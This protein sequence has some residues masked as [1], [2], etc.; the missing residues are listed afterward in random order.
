M[1]KLSAEFL[2]SVGDYMLVET[3]LAKADLCLV[4]GCEQ[5]DVLTTR[6]A[7]LYHKGYFP[8]IVVSGGVLTSKGMLE[9]HQMH[10]RLVALGVPEDAI[11]VEDKATNTG[12]NVNFSMDLLKT[13]GE[14]DKVKS[15]LAVGQVHA[16]RRFLMTLE[17]QWPDPVKMLTAPDTFPVP[18]KDWYTDRKFRHAV[19]RELRKI[20]KYKVRGFIREINLTSMAKK[21]ADLP[22]PGPQPKRPPPPD[23]PKP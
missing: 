20:P 14:F 22:Q 7:E 21:I 17:K 15:I 3:P 16:A 6:A 2:K 12:E 1:K 11:R 18:R 13:T 23:A 5:A 9:A 4:F 19:L 10:D 8:L